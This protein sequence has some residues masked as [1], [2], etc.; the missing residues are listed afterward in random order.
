MAG[1]LNKQQGNRV[2]SDQEQPLIAGPMD[3]FCKALT[4]AEYE[5][6]LRTLKMAGVQMRD[7]DA[8]VL[9]AHIQAQKKKKILNIRFRSS[10][11]FGFC[12]IDIKQNSESILLYFHPNRS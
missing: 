12:A 6:P 11:N 3:D 9:A 1:L 7:A 10:H 8:E 4:S 5:I 2:V